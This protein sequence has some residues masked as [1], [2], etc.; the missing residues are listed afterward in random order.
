MDVER[1]FK[2]ATG[3][4]LRD[5]V[6]R[7]VEVGWTPLGLNSERKFNSQKVSS[8]IH[9]KHRERIFID[10]LFWQSLGEALGW[11]NIPYNPTI[12]MYKTYWQFSQ[13]RFVDTL[14]SQIDPLNHK[15]HE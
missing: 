7:A 5:G 6:V 1:A 14:N 3:L 9:T 8:A 13:H 11:D 4:S 15:D 10:P 12:G 2:E